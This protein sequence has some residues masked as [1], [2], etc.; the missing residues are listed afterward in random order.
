MRGIEKR[1]TQRFVWG[2][3][4]AYGLEL[5]RHW[6]RP[7]FRTPLAVCPRQ[8]HQRFDAPP[9]GPRAMAATQ[10]GPAIP[11]PSAERF[12][13]RSF[14]QPVG[15]A[16]GRTASLA[17]TS[18]T[19]TPSRMSGCSTSFRNAPAYA[20]CARSTSGSWN[21]CYPKAR[22]KGCPSS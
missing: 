11:H 14:L 22:A 6:H 16:S 13:P 20:G 3:T 19:A 7:A 1:L 10:S 8:L 15:A 18:P 12:D 4:Q 21:P 2:S 9:Q 17:P 5:A